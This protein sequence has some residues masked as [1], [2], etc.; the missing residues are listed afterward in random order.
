M[1]KA[2]MT[3]LAG[4]ALLSAGC[5]DDLEGKAKAFKDKA[6]ACK[7]AKCIE[8]LKKDMESLEKAAKG[9][10]ESEQMKALAPLMEAAACAS[11][12]GGDIGL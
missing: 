6:C 10:S 11:K 4:L 3:V 9:A 7:D 5:G 8:G 2:I 12:V 1:K